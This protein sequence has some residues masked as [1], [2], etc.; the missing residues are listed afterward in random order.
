MGIEKTCNNCKYKNTCG[1]RIDY[2]NEACEEHK[3][4]TKD[5]EKRV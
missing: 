4:K 3:I 1:L 2:N 5:Y